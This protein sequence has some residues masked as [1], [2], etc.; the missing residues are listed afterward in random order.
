VTFRSV[1]RGD[2]VRIRRRYRDRCE[3]EFAVVK[4]VEEREVAP[5]RFAEYFTFVPVH[6]V[7]GHYGLPRWA[8]GLWGCTWNQPEDLKKPFSSDVDV[9][10]PG[11]FAPACTCSGDET[12]CD[13][14]D[15]C[16]KVRS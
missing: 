8:C 16:P 9:V 6:P 2:V 7:R 4:E 14:A 1:N 10:V 12:G 13:H 3:V 5:G 11:L 15:W